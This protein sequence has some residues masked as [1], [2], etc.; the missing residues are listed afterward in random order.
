MTELNLAPIKA[1]EQAATPGPWHGDRYDGTL[2]YKLRGAN[3][4]I[5]LV[6]EHKSCDFGFI[7]ENGDA[8]EEFVIHARTD[9]PALLAEVE[10][11]RAEV[12]ALVNDAELGLAVR[13]GL[14]KLAEI[15]GVVARLSY[16]PELKMWGAGCSIDGAWI[17]S[18]EPDNAID[19]AL[20]D[21]LRKDDA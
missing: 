1:R 17:F 13:E 4:A 15:Y 5:V 20:G 12:A 9:M 3:N 8:D 2:K 21:A 16:D 19:T 11:L 14:P 10:R 6:V 7:G 18:C